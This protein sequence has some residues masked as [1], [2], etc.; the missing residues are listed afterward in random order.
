MQRLSGQ[1][2]HV[3]A[4]GRSHDVRELRDKSEYRKLH[5]CR[6]RVRRGFSINILS[7]WLDFL[8]YPL[9]SDLFCTHA[10]RSFSGLPKPASACIYNIQSIL[11]NIIFVEQLHNMWKREVGSIVKMA[12]MSNGS[13]FHWG[14]FLYY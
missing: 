13:V 14:C 7:V 10:R 12:D 11:N 9:S 3:V 6:M 2:S 4:C 1:K 8:D 5:V